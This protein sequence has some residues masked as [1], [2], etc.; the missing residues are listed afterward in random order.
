MPYVL[1]A[2]VKSYKDGSGGDAW[3]LDM[4]D[5]VSGSE[6]IVGTVGEE[7]ERNSDIPCPEL[8]S[9]GVTGARPVKLKSD[10]PTP[11]TGSKYIHLQSN[12]FNNS[13]NH[14]SQL[15]LGNGGMTTFAVM[16]GNIE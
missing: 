6:G 14:S 16:Q 10:N 12:S 11:S 1:V 8:S 7:S 4:T 15:D 3:N 5:E 2:R 13:S 9:S